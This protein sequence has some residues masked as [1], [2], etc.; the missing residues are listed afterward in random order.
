MVLP[1]LLSYHFHFYAA[2]LIN[3]TS[4]NIIPSGNLESERKKRRK[5]EKKKDRRLFF[6]RLGRRN[7]CATQK[8]ARVKSVRIKRKR[9]GEKRGGNEGFHSFNPSLSLAHP[10]IQ[11]CPISSSK[12]SHLCRASCRGSEEVG[13]LCH[14]CLKSSPTPCAN[15]KLLQSFECIPYH[16]KITNTKRRRIYL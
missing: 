1:S 4:L 2:N 14:R 3:I 6:A 16:F 13:R 15:S 11:L 8:K 10:L 7:F 9:G 12:H 5:G